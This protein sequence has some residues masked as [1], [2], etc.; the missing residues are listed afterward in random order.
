MEFSCATV[1]DYPAI[2][3]LQYAVMYK[4]GNPTLR[5]LLRTILC[6]IMAIWFGVPVVFLL[7]TGAADEIRPVWF[8]MTLLFCTLFAVNLYC[9]IGLPKAAYRANSRNGETQVVYT[10]REGDFTV[11]AVANGVSSS[12]TVAYSSLFGAYRTEGYYLLFMAKNHA[13]LVSRAALSPEQDVWMA[14]TLRFA[15]GKAYRICK[16]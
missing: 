13:N 5:V 11:D 9:H 15:L 2:K 8:G 10:F 16:F 7:C 6:G 12:S 4:T 3:A 1:Y 14:N